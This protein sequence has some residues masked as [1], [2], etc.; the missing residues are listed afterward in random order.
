LEKFLDKK[1][2]ILRFYYKVALKKGL[3]NNILYCTSEI[4]VS[5]VRCRPHKWLWKILEHFWRKKG[6]ILSLYK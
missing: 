5:L 3:K 4:S 2:K 1:G 6:K